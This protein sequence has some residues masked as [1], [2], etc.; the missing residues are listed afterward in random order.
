MPFHKLTVYVLLIFMATLVGYDS[1]AMFMTGS[2]EQTLSNALWNFCH[3]FPELPFLFGI[4]SGHLFARELSSTIRLS[5][6][7]IG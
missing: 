7:S 3:H 6:G 5:H 4:F 1:I 2:E